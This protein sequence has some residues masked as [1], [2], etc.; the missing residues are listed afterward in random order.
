M[1]RANTRSQV[2]PHNKLNELTGKE[3]LQF[4]KTWFIH[5]PSPRRSAEQ[6]HPGKFPESLVSEFICYFTKPGEWVLDPFCGTG[7]A[8]IAALREGRNAVGCE[9]NAPWAQQAT[10]RVKSGAGEVL[11]KTGHAVCPAD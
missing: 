10:E 4:T 7:S 5:N 1:A 9:L 8:L 2:A 11:G 3:W 6:H